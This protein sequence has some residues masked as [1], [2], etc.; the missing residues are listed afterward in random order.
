MTQEFSLNKIMGTSLSVQGLRLPAPNAGSSGSF[1]GWGAT[2]Q[3]AF[4]HGQKK[5]FFNGAI[6]IRYDF[7]LPPNSTSDRE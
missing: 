7:H 4:G 1:P 5:F 3:H 6:L 2:I